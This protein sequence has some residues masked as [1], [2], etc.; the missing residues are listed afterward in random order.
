MTVSSTLASRTALAKFPAA[1]LRVV[2]M[3]QS[4][5]TMGPSLHP[6]LSNITSP[7]PTHNR[8]PLSVRSRSTTVIPQK[9]TPARTIM[10]WGEIIA[11]NLHCTI[12]SICD[13]ACTVLEGG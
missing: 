8:V 6:S 3:D 13:L 7:S 1:R 12:V 5:L 2:S 4:A 10:R 9:S 11:D